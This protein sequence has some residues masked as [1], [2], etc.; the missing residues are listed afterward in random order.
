M[1]DHEDEAP[2]RLS[3]K[4]G[5]QDEH[6]HAFPILVRAVHNAGQRIDDDDAGNDLSPSCARSS[7]IRGAASPSARPRFGATVMSVERDGG[8]LHQGPLPAAATRLPNA[9]WPSAAT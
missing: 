4:T 8:I 1:V 2:K 6:A 7:S 5:V 3:D 9:P